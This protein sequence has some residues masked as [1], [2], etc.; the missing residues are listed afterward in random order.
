MIGTRVAWICIKGPGIEWETAIKSRIEE[1][2]DTREKSQVVSIGVLP[3]NKGV[4][5]YREILSDK[6]SKT[7]ATCTSKSWLADE[8]DEDIDKLSAKLG[9]GSRFRLTK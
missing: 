3:Y 8:G 2:L 7:S 6:H 1:V 9:W 5:P 4:I